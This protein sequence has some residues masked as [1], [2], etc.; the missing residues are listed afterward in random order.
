[1]TEDREVIRE[2]EDKKSKFSFFG[3]K[4]ETAPKKVS[5]PPGVNSHSI[6]R[7]ESMSPSAT[8]AGDDLPP[9]TSNDPATPNDEKANV[10][11]YAGFD[12][13]AIKGAIGKEDLEVKK[14]PVPRPGV[15]P[16][17]TLALSRPSQPLERSESAPP[18]TNSPSVS[19]AAPESP[20]TPTPPV[21]QLPCDSTAEIPSALSRSLSMDD[22]PEDENEKA[23]VSSPISPTTPTLPLRG[24]FANPYRQTSTSVLSFGSASGDI[25]A[26]GATPSTDTQ[27]IP[28]RVDG[29]T[30]GGNSNPYRNYSPPNSY[31]FS[32][33]SANEDE[34]NALAT[35][36]TL[37]FAGADGLISDAAEDPWKPKPVVGEH[38]KDTPNPWDS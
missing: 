11:K 33:G 36:T 26:S 23:S 16:V 8:I 27:L 5:R 25:W 10:Q 20:D 34:P 31:G 13:Q 38:R 2:G 37:T 1:M 21:V 24:T 30:F 32:N 15:E 22:L 9:R 29:T 7:T 12:F 19:I 35:A 6:S 4:E 14:I 3:R 18:L 28:G 17:S